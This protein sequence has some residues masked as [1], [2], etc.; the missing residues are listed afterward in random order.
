[1]G[2]FSTFFKAVGVFVEA[3]VYAVGTVAAWV[4]EKT[5]D[6]IDVAKQ[7]YGDYKQR[8]IPLEKRRNRSQLSDVNEKIR[9]YEM[10]KRRD[11]SLS[12]YD[13]YEIQKLKSER[14]R[15]INE[16][17][18]HIEADTAAAIAE[19]PDSFEDVLIDDSNIHIIQFHV[20][21]AVSGKKCVCGRPMILQWKRGTTRA[22]MHDLFWGCTGF[23]TAEC[24]RKQNFHPEDARLFTK[25]TRPEFQITAAQL[26]TITNNPSAKSNITKRLNSMR[27]EVIEKYLCPEHG[28]ELV[29]KEK[30]NADGV[31][32]QFFLGCPLWKADDTGCNFV[33]KLK[34]PAQLASVLESHDGRGIL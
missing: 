8:N 15:L 13:L 1:M 11:G 31:M 5:A 26:T 16:V 3:A 20:G 34:S 2:F 9:Y 22:S 25:T 10:K 4:G 12:Q 7:A 24:Y 33:M 29:L 27:N 14:H 6:L 21:Q 30:K 23:Y 28:V 17:L 32:D 18:E 19:E